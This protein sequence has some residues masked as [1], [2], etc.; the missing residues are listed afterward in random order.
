MPLMVGVSMV[1]YAIGMVIVYH[2][3]P[4]FEKPQKVRI[5][6]IGMV[7][8]LILT[9]ILCN[10]V[11]GKIEGYQ[12]ELIDTTKNIAILLFSPINFIILIPYL[13]SILSKN[14]DEAINDTQLKK[15]LFILAILIVI[16]IIV[17]LGYIK[18]FCLG[19][20]FSIVNK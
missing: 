20:L 18:D 14:K 2:N 11:A 4:A 6:A 13:G 9:F 15:R 19:S 8:T 5:I 7:V 16:I 17:E 3:I 12:K 10:I 1:L